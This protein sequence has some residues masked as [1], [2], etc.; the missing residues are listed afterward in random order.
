MKVG[1]FDP[2]NRTGHDRFS[3]T[4]DGPELVHLKSAEDAVKRESELEYVLPVGET[5]LLSVFRAGINSGIV[6]VG[7]GAGVPS[8]PETAFA[9]SLESLTNGVIE[10]VAI[11]TIDVSLG[12]EEFRALMDVMAV[13]AEPARISEFRTTKGDGTVVDT[14]RADGVVISAPGGTPGYGTAVDGPIL[15][16]SVDGLS[17]V[18]VGQFR[19]A[20]PRW[21]LAPPIEIEV[22]RETVPIAL[23]V[24]DREVETIPANTSLRLAWGSPVEFAVLE[25]SNGVFW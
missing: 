10:S 16:P 3:R 13:T 2:E 8:V 11:P 19:T 21:V 1:L 22:V 23:V 24:D 18:P 5:A 4:A 20:H 17:V 25:Q 7:I 6:P 15:D 9:A 14:V 12:E